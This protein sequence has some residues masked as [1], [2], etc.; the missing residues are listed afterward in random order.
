M[1]D[2]GDQRSLKSALA[3]FP[4]FSRG[5]VK[6]QRDSLAGSQVGQGY[7]IALDISEHCV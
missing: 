5:W 7:F 2:G 3:D 1:G 4:D 6:P